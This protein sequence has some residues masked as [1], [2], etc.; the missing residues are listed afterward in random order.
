VKEIIRRFVRSL[1][2]DIAKFNESHP[3]VRRKL[4]VQHHGIKTVLDVG[5]SAGQ[6]GQ[7]M[8]NDIAYTGRMVSFEPLSTPFATLK[9]LAEGD[10]G[11]NVFRYGLGDTNGNMR[12]NVSANSCSSS[13][14]AV[15]GALLAVAPQVSVVGVEDVEVRTLDSVFTSLAC[16]EPIYMKIDTQGFEDRVLRGAEQSVSHISVIQLE[17]ALAP[18]YEG[19]KTFMEVGAMLGDFGYSLVSLEP[20]LADPKTGHLLEVDG[21]FERARRPS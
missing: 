5:A 10:G 17:M 2:Y 3:F 20:G 13:M 6:F 15:S 7:H 1:G 18:M 21:T 14:L 16:E 8:R 11:W 19:S 9:R 12:M 4:I